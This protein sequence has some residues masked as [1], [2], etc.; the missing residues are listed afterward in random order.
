MSELEKCKTC[1]EYY[2][3]QELQKAIAARIAKEVSDKFDRLMDKHEFMIK[4]VPYVDC[5][6]ICALTENIIEIYTSTQPQSDSVNEASCEC[7]ECQC[8]DSVNN[9]IE[10]RYGIVTSDDLKQRIADSV[11]DGRETERQK[12]LKLKCGDC[13]QPRIECE[14]GSLI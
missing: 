12:Y 8:I 10:D 14:C 5:N 7:D 4:G 9:E 2:T 6:Y 13:N 3:Y 1:N 11:N